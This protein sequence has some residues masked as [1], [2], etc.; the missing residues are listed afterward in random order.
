[1]KVGAASMVASVP[2]TVRTRILLNTMDA[3]FRIQALEEAV[4]QFGVPEIFNT[5]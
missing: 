4:A 5:D 1:V 3:E 2:P